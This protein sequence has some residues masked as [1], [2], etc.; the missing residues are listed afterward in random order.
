MA[1]QTETIDTVPAHAVVGVILALTI[2]VSAYLLFQVQPLISKFILPWF[3]G[4]PAVW[5]T[6]M[7]FFQ[8]LLFFGYSYAH[9]VSRFLSIRQQ[10]LVHIALVMLAAYLATFIIPGEYFKPTGAESPIWQILLLLGACVGIPYFCLAT[11]GP[12]IQYWFSHAYPG[13]SP[14]R[15]YSLSNLGSFL[16]LLSFPYLFE[17]F[18]ELPQLGNYW[19]I[20]FWV[21]ASFCIAAAFQMFQRHSSFSSVDHYAYSSEERIQSELPSHTQRVGWVVLPALASL[22]FIATTD[23]VSHDIAPE[24]RLWITTLGLY[25][26][27]F[28][29]CFDHERWYR[30]RLTAILC[31]LTIL[32]VTGRHDIPLG[33]GVDWKFGITEVRWSH[34]LVMFLICFMCHGELVRLRPKSREYLTEFYLWMSF[35]GACGGLFVMLVATNLFDDFYEWALCLL[36][37]IALAVYILASTPTPARQTVQQPSS[38]RVRQFLFGAAGLLASGVAGFWLDPFEWR[39]GSSLEFEEDYL[40]RSRNFYGTVAVEERLHRADPS[41]SHRVFYS[42]QINHGVQFTH[43]DKRALPLSY[44][45]IESGGGE[46]LEYVK[47]K[48]PEIRVAIVGLG[49]GTLAT[50]A[51]ESDHYDL[52][53]INPDVIQIANQ[54]FDNVPRCKARTKETILGDA[55]LKLE[56]ASEDIQYD[57]IVLDA[58]SGDSVPIHLLTREAFEIYRRHLKPKGFIVVHI[59]NRYLNLYPVVRRQAEHLGMSF[60]NKFQSGEPSRLIRSNHYFIMTNDFEYLSS[61]PSINPRYFDDN[62]DLIREV[63]PN[64]SN[65]PLWTDHFSSINPI[66]IRN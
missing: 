33:L 61:F 12:L 32:V 34:F 18:F 58:F 46:T 24:P 30:R 1:Q 56:Q 29:I 3:G 62:G 41:R 2:L 14:Y 4:S 35:G 45:S 6:A 51:R 64:I 40:H 44:Y 55:R 17:P 31:L 63:D 20:G 15:L 49:I 25:L 9:L 39:E 43:V 47:S 42:G 65:V 57:V 38:T 52:F 16:G 7:L 54:W 19:T 10:T 66:E 5:T 21:F 26:L 50:Y 8:C 27:T 60:R 22:A 37:A 28:I 23:R 13:R 11:T 59:T 36:A 53:E 48:Y